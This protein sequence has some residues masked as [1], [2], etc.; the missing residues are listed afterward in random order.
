M[1]TKALR[2]GPTDSPYKSPATVAKVATRTGTGSPRQNTVDAHAPTATTAARIALVLFLFRMSLPE[3]ERNHFL[4]ETA[5]ASFN[6]F[7]A[8]LSSS[9]KGV[10]VFATI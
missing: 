2:L 3:K 7:A 4:S 10:T 8:F 1:S 9:T 6:S 5:F